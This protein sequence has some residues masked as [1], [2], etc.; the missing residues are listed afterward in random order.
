VGIEAGME[1]ADLP[2]LCAQVFLCVSRADI[3]SCSG[4]AGWMVKNLLCWLADLFAVVFK[5]RASP[6]RSYHKQI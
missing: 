2:D 6:G 3:D 5:P 1:V 4:A